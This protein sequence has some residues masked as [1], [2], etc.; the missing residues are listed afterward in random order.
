MITLQRLHAGRTS[1]A[2]YFALAGATFG[3]W[4]GRVPAVIEQIG[5]SPGQLGAALAAWSAAAVLALPVTGAL[6]RRLGSPTMALASLLAFTACLALLPLVSTFGLFTLVLCVFGAANSGLDVAIN[7]QS[8]HVERGYQRPILSGFH[9][10]FSV[11]TVLGGLG[12]SVAA[13]LQVPVALHFAVMAL[14]CAVVGALALRRLVPDPPDTRH[15][16][17][18]A[19][20]G[21]M[22]L[23]PGLVLFCAAGIEDIASSWT[24]VYLRAVEAGPGFAAAGYTLFT[25]AMLAGRAVT[26][27]ARTRFGDATLLRASGLLAVTGGLLAVLVPHPAT[28][29]IGFVAVG[30]GIAC[31]FPVMLSRVGQQHTSTTAQSLAA[32]STIAYLGSLAGPSTV[33]GIAGYLGLDTALL[34]VPLLA[35]VVVLLAGRFTPQHA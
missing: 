28:V 4:A 8:V 27:R 9:A 10:L 23:L 26:D 6:V 22:L 11:G 32:V 3:T 5:L 14:T 20:P 31:L 1:V 12:G 18:L 33:G 19:W 30:A 17:V 2:V 29:A 35:T 7:A 34:L 21:K 13:A 24:A 15:G 25:A 16:R